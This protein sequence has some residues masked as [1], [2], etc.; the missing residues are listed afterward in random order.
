MVEDS[1]FKTGNPKQKLCLHS[2]S[3]FRFVQILRR[4]LPANKIF[5][6]INLHL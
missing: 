6:I 1:L 4:D 5:N 3:A 2:S